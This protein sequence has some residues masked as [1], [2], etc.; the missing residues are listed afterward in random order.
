MNYQTTIPVLKLLGAIV[1]TREASH[2]LLQVVENNP[3]DKVDID[4]SGVEFISR[5]FA[6]QFHTDTLALAERTNKSI[7]ITN[8]N[9]PVINMLQAVAKTQDKA[10]RHYSKI[11]VYK[12]SSRSSLERFL[13]SF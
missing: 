3:C 12:Y 9:E 4:F 5:S 6:D 10:R 1:H 11:P 7:I 13:I 8:A 2:I